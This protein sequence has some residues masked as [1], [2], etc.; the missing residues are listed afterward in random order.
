MFASI[1]CISKQFKTA[2]FSIIYVDMQISLSLRGVYTTLQIVLSVSVSQNTNKLT[3]SGLAFSSC[4]FIMQ[5]QV[6]NEAV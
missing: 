1:L 3:F 5:M 4:S 6:W 2:I